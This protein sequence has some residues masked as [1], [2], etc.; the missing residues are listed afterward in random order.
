MFHVVL[1]LRFFQLLNYQ[2]AGATSPVR[3]FDDDGIDS[4]GEFLQADGR[5]AAVAFQPKFRHFLAKRV[6]DGQHGA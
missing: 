1:V 6:K 3:F 2:L 5:A 4:G